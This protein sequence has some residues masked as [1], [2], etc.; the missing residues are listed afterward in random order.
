M[1]RNVDV[2]PSQRRE[3]RTADGRWKPGVV[4]IG[5]RPW[6]KG[7]AP[8]PSGKGGDYHEALKLARETSRR[9]IERLIELRESSDEQIATVASKALWEI[10]WGRPKD[11][12]PR[13][14]P[15]INKPKF[16][17]RL[18]SP[19]ELNVVEFALRLISRATRLLPECGTECLDEGAPK[20]E[21]E[22]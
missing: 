7:Q 9:S 13:T 14:E 2:L 1:E 5:A 22:L 16:D 18:L 6:Q 21:R 11:Y 17:P 4:P 8:N 19:E 20:G 10:S 12:D 15:D 3:Q